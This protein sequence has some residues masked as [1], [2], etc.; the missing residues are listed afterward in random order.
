M[1]L[2]CGVDGA[3]KKINSLYTNIDGSTK[4]IKEM[5]VG[6]DGAN[7]KLYQ[8]EKSSK[9]IAAWFTTDEQEIHKLTLKKHKRYDIWVIGEGTSG[10]RGGDNWGLYKGKGGGCGAS[11]SAAHFSF[12][13]SS[14]KLYLNSSMT[15]AD[16]N[17]PFKISV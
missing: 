12:V 1:S 13:T 8:A 5:Y 15:I 4:Q 17:L 3:I 2:Y 10:S 6:I 14:N 7:T 11:G 16:P 9:I